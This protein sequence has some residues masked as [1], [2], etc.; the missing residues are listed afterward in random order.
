MLCCAN[1]G[2]AGSDDIKLMDCSACHLVKYCSV[3]CQ[4]GHWP[5][6]EK[7]C[8]KRAAE[9]H[10][11]ILFKQPESNHYGDCPICYLPLPL[12]PQKATMNS[13]CSKRI[14]NGCNYANQKREDEG[15]LQK[16]C[17]LCRTALPKTDEQNIEQVRKRIEVND[18]V[19]MLYMGTERY[20]KRDYKAAFEYCTRAAELGDVEAHYRLSSL[21]YTGQGVEKDEKRQLH[22]AEQAAIGGHPI[23]RHDLG[24]RE[25]ENGRVDRAVKHLIIAAKL[26]YDDSLDA[27]KKIHKA[28][29]VSKEDDFATALRGHHAAID[30][31][32]SPQRE[33]A[34]AVKKRLA[35][36]ERKGV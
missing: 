25:W 18:P 27:L 32:E 2:A 31:T 6:H 15:R 10:D 19:A 21:Y 35:E 4:K 29:L 16:K 12:D 23:A 3:K 9:L 26:G 30:A 14:C 36:R 7:E 17:A 28:G 13:C 33:E 34:A 22:H 20:N 8:K 1:C 5:K 24:V 11:E